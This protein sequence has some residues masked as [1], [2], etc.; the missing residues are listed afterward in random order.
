MM[1]EKVEMCEVA[2]AY[3]VQGE[4]HIR[5]RMASDKELEELCGLANSA[6]LPTS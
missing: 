4:K 1:P 5:F 3:E 6:T 2:C